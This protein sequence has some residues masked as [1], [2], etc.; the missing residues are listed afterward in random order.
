MSKYGIYAY[1]GGG[2]AQVDRDA[3]PGYLTYRPVWHWG[4]MWSY[5]TRNTGKWTDLDIV[6]IIM[7]PQP[8]TLR[9]A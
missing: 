6:P 1:D 8:Y 7:H 3:Q 2:L 5:V 9:Y 4:R